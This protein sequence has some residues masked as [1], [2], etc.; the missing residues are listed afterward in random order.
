ME[1]CVMNIFLFHKITLILFS[2]Y[3]SY[4]KLEFL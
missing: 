2:L 1:H 3:D 4:S